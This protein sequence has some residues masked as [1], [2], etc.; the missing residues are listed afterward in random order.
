MHLFFYL[1]I[2][3]IPLALMGIILHQLF[4]KK[5]KVRDVIPDM[6]ATTFYLGV[7]S[8]IGYSLLN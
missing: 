5:K 6:I 3:I 8:W 2:C 7:W 1:K 4:T